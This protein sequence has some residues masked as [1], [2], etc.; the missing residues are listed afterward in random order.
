[1]K[2]II[3]KYMDEAAGH[4]KYQKEAINAVLTAMDKVTEL[5]QFQETKKDCKKAMI[6]L[7]KVK[8]IMVDIKG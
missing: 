8:K 7:D 6:L 2:N 3:E 4:E 5:S 1:M